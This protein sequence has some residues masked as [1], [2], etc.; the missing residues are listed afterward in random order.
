MSLVIAF[1]A[2]DGIVLAADSRGTTGPPG[3]LQAISDVYK[4]IY[5]LSSHCGIG[6]ARSSELGS[7]LLDRMGEKVAAESCRYMDDVLAFVRNQLRE[8]FND[9][10]S[11]I[12]L[13]ERPG[14]LLLV[15]GYRRLKR[16]RLH[17]MI[18]LLPSQQDFAPLLMAKGRGMIGVPQYAI[19]LANRYFVPNM[20]KDNVA[21]L[22]EFLI[23]ETATQDPKVGGPINIAVITPKQGYQEFSEEAV[24]ALRKANR[25]KSRRLR[26]WFF[27]GR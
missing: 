11:R 10:F 15:A 21:A 19:Y 23:Y 25:Q 26:I 22:S 20:S 1:Q 12:P 3:G 18:Y 27:R 8:Q 5:R 7:A 9:W 16:K 4:K 24:S 2:K 17:P 13:K 14:V 6:I